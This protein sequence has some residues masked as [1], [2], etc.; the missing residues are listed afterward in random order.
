MAGNENSGRRPN[1]HELDIRKLLD[2][3]YKIQMEFLDDETVPLEK[4]VEYASRYLAKRVGEK[5]DVEVRHMLDEN[6]MAQLTGRLVELKLI[7][8]NTRPS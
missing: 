6:Q 3:S 4:K 1:F 7:E 5:I 8:S 2:K